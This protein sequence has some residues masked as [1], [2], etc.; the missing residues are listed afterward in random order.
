MGLFI[1]WIIGCFIAAFIGSN[2]T[3]G[4]WGAFFLSLIL[5]PLIGIIA[6]LVSKD[7]SEMEIQKTILAN[8]QSRIYDKPASILSVADEIAKFKSLLDDGTISQNEFDAYKNQLIRR[9]ST[10]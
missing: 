10:D 4:F 5:S 2:K 1:G 9:K 3:I 7:Q 8:Q 6:A